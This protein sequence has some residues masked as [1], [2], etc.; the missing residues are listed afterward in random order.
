M[1]YTFPSRRSVVMALGGMVAGGV[2]AAEQ[3]NPCRLNRC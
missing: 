3:E 2:I 1:A